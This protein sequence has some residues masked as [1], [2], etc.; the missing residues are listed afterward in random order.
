MNLL[1][2][3][4]GLI[5]IVSA[6]QNA[7]IMILCR[8][9]D[10]NDIAKTL[11]N[12]EEKF[13]KKHQYPYVFLNDQEFTED[14][15]ETLNSVTQHRADY[16]IIAPEDWDMPK[17][18]NLKKAQD[19]WTVMRQQGVPY[20]ET[21]SYH[22]MCRYFSRTFYKHPLVQKYEYYWRIEPSVTFHCDI[23]YDV[24]DKMK[25]NNYQYSFVI[26]IY[27][28][29]ATIK[30]LMK[31]TAQF[32]LENNIENKNSLK[33]MFERGKYNGCHFWSN[34]EIASFDFFR[35][36]TYNDYV[37]F[38]EKTGG[39]YYE[40][41]GDAPIHSIAAAL[42]LNKEQ[43][44]FFEDIGY[45]HD[46]FMHCPKNGKNCNCDP[47]RSVDFTYSSCLPKYL[48]EMRGQQ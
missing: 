19:Y 20:A 28:Y 43:V 3:C 47:A 37:D 7:V 12:F 42:F 24:F 4:L 2:I 16:G 30:S 11:T 14:F 18:I 34:F 36:K 41:W 29:M 10:K 23:D 26:T 48:N 22:N 21:M 39:F 44:H 17:N 1:K 32:L 45:T 5:S 38:L 13:N 46:I 33:F 25:E 9:S 40:R 15:K 35:L 31:T 6:K 8:N 27:E